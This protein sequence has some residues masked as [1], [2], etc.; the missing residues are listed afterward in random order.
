MS[1]PR[2]IFNMNEPHPL[3]LS[4]FNETVKDLTLTASKLGISYAAVNLLYYVLLLPIGI[5]AG[6][7]GVVK[8]LF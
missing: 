5:I 7:Y 2:A 6:Y 1:D 8:E 3:Y 4:K